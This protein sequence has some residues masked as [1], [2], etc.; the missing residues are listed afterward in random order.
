MRPEEQQLLDLR[1]LVVQMRTVKGYVVDRLEKPPL[2][3]PDC[4]DVNGRFWWYQIID[5]TGLVAGYFHV[6]VGVEL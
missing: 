1:E 5:D 2:H 6:P 3:H 4:D